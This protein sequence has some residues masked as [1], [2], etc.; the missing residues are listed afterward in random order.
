MPGSKQCLECFGSLSTSAYGARLVS[1]FRRPPSGYSDPTHL[2][3][4]QDFLTPGCGYS[5][6]RLP[7]QLGSN[8]PSAEKCLCSSWKIVVIFSL[9][10]SSF[11]PPSWQFCWAISITRSLYIQFFYTYILYFSRIL[12]LSILSFFSLCNGELYKTPQ[13]FPYYLRGHSCIVFTLQ[14]IMASTQ[15]LSRHSDTFWW[16]LDPCVGHL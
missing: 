7:Y 14:Y 1:T 2:Y 6:L 11:F 10:L 8:Q 5:Q 3:R 16:C 12:S 13:S 4:Q 9:F 15:F